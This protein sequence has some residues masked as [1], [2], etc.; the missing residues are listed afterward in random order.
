MLP[1]PG[2]FQAGFLS[3]YGRTSVRAD[4]DTYVDAIF[5]QSSQLSAWAASNPRLR[6]K[7]ALVQ[8]L[9]ISSDPRFRAVFAGL[10]L[11]AAS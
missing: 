7:I 6:Q 1:T 5:T 11:P 9:L 4:F 3:D 2:L 8:N 10:G